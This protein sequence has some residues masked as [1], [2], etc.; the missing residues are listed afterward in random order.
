MTWQI[1]ITDDV[2]TALEERAKVY[3][4]D[5]EFTANATLALIKAYRKMRDSFGPEAESPAPATTLRREIANVL[6]RFSAENGSNTPDHL[7]TEFI[8]GCLSAWNATTLAR[9]RWYGVRLAPGH[10]DVSMK[11]ADH[12]PDCEMVTL[13]Q[14]CTCKA[15]GSIRKRKEL[16]RPLTDFMQVPGSVCPACGEPQYDTPSGKACENGHGY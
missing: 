1:E 11:A 14:S 6:N 15:S 9:D 10:S 7:L 5:N 16:D 8:F 12:E 13:H 2:L 4:D 3:A